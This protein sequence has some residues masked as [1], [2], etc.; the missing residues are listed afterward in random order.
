MFFG[1]EDHEREERSDL[2]AGTIVQRDDART[3]RCF[4]KL[5]ER[6]GAECRARVV[7]DDAAGGKGSS[8]EDLTLVQ[9]CWAERLKLLGKGDAS[10]AIAR[11]T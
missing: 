11:H 2:V 3:G 1:F 6:G 5:R 10:S 4:A 9:R 8:L 7:H